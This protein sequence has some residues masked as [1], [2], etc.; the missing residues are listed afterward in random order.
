[1]ASVESRLNL[2]GTSSQDSERCSSA[3]SVNDLLSDL[4]E[5]PE[6][7]TRRILDM[8]MFDDIPVERKTMK[9]N[10]RQMLKSSLEMQRNL[11]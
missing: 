9:E 1:M 7:F 3:V 10:A 4:G 8:S 5:A 11:V 2:S 6:T